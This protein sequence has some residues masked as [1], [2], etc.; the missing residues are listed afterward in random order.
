ME[1]TER[2]DSH[3]DSDCKMPCEGNCQE[4]VKQEAFSGRWYITMGHAGFN[5][6]AN[7]RTGYITEKSA[8][9]AHAKYSGRR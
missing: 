1:C 3:L 8:Q 9:S 2:N 7:N 6:P 5:N 4:I